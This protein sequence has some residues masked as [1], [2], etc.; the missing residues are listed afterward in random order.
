MDQDCR[1]RTTNRIRKGGNAKKMRRT[2]SAWQAPVLARFVAIARHLIR[3]TGSAQ[4]CD[5]PVV[6]GQECRSDLRQGCVPL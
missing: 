5:L 1:P 2:G 4:R 6:R 3:V